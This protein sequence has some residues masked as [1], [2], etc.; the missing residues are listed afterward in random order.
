[1]KRPSFQFYPGDWLNDASLRMVSVGARGLWMEMICLMHQG[2]EYGHLKVNG[3]V[4]APSQLAR[5]VGEGIG[6]VEGWLNELE[7]AGVFTLD[8]EAIVS[9]RMIRDEEVRNLRA[10][11]GK[12]GGNP[13]LVGEYNEPGFIYA[14]QRSGDGAIKIGIS[15]HPTK[16]AYRIRQQYPNEVITLLAQLHVDDM[17]AREKELHRLYSHCKDGE[18]FSLSENERVELLNIHLKVNA[19][20]TLTPS[21]SS[22]SSSSTTT[23]TTSEHPDV[24][25]NAPRTHVPFVEII[26][27]Y[28]RLLPELPRCAKLTDRRKGNIRQRW[29][30]D[31]SDLPAWEDYF[32]RIVRDSDF[33]MGQSVGTNGKPPFRAD[34]EWL[35][36]PNN[37]VK[38]CEGKYRGKIK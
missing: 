34:L 38:V 37:I 25:A 26:D 10:A 16:R 32:G 35:V 7:I 3:K 2:S 21:S 9:R 15:K 8:G 24:G 30:Q 14:M 4:I 31:L 1:M 20:A 28:H 5:I 23:T 13:L 17:G 19:K 18:W 29:Q 6:E 36:N 33:L 12:N 27:L 11:G 22:S